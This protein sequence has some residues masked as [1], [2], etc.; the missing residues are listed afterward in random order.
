M[1]KTDLYIRGELNNNYHSGYIVLNKNLNK[2][3]IVVG[4]FLGNDRKTPRYKV[5]KEGATVRS[6]RS[7]WKVDEC[8]VVQVI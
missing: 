5:R 1:N 6:D 2:R 3:G 4:C 7:D 8:T